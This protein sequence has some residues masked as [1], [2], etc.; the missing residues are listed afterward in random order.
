[1]PLEYVIL[2]F[3]PVTHIDAT[4]LHTLETIVET[5]AGHGTQVVLANPS[6]EIIA[7]MRRGGLFDMI[8]RDY[9]FITVNEVGAAPRLMILWGER[10]WR[11]SD[12]APR[13]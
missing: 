7:L 3:S 10:C 13:R 6:Q 2:D 11:V 1:M 12:A 8:G 5:L 4:G 9:V